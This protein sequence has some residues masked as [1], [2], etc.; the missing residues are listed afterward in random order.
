MRLITA[1]P[2]RMQLDLGLLILR[3]ITGIVMFAHGSQKLFTYGIPG[4][5]GSFTQMGAPMPA[6]TA[7]LVAF[8]EFLCGLALVFGILTR[9]AAVPIAIDM[10][11]AIL[12]VHLK[13]GFF[14]PSGVEF[15]LTL[16]SVAIAIIFLGAG[17]YSVD[18]AIEH[19]RT[20]RL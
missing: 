15:P 17:T 1:T 18:G 4:V 9:L 13:N 5:V 10:A 14:S 7:P 12:I 19:R 16:L 3:V 11:S 20:G 6:I 8:V 2:S